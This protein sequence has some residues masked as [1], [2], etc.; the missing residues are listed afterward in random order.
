[1]VGGDG[2]VWRGGGAYLIYVSGNLPVTFSPQERGWVEGGGGGREVRQCDKELHA[3]DLLYG[4]IRVEQEKVMIFLSALQYPDNQSSVRN[5]KIPVHV[6][7]GGLAEGGRVPHQQHI[8]PQDA[9]CTI[10]LL[11]AQ[12]EIYLS[13]KRHQGRRAGGGRGHN[14]LHL[15]TWLGGKG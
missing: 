5:A 9:P 2:R 10:T 8:W 1:M 11:S 13:G 12:A 15:D 3:L 7:A 4:C 14:N 6:A